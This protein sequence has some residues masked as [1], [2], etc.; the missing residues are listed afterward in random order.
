MKNLDQIKKILNFDP[1]SQAEEI[2]GKSYK[3]DKAINKQTF[4]TM[5][6]LEEYYRNNKGD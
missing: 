2:T 1:L 4:P 5:Q 6:E 3:E